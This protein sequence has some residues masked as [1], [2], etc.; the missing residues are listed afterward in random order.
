MKL[1][2]NP[3]KILLSTAEPEEQ[4]TTFGYGMVQLSSPDELMHIMNR[5]AVATGIYLNGHRSGSHLKAMGNVY[6][7]DIDTAPATGD[8]P[9]YQA[10][11]AKLRSLNISFV[12]VP[13]RNANEYPYKR[14][15]AIILDGNLPKQE[16]SFIEAANHILK[17]I[18]IDAV[19]INKETT[20][21]DSDNIDKA[22]AFDRV[23]FLAPAGINKDFTNYG[24]LSHA[25]DGEALKLPDHLKTV[26]AGTVNDDSITTS[27]MIQFVDG[28]TISIYNA[29]KI[30]PKGTKR[31]C[32]CPNPHHED[33]RPS[34]VFYHNDKNIV[35]HCSKCGNIKVSTNFI[36]TVP[37]IVH[38]QYNYSI[39]L[40]NVLQADLSRLTALIG[41]YS[42]KTDTS[43]IWAYRVA[44]VD[45][46]YQLL[47]AKVWLVENG[48]EVSPQPAAK[49]HSNLLDTATLQ[50]TTK[51]V[52]LPKAFVARD[53]DANAFTMLYIR[54]S[55]LIFKHYLFPEVTIHAY[56]QNIIAPDRSFANTCNRGL[57]YF[58]YVIETQRNQQGYPQSNKYF[59]MKLSRSDK[60]KSDK[61]RI[62]GMN[63]TRKAKTATAE[64]QVMKLI[65]NKKFVKANGKPNVSAIAKT[66]DKSRNTIYAA[67]KAI[68]E[69]RKTQ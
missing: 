22:V 45:D 61:Q 25:Y 16:D 38:D 47:L 69:R 27:Q 5:K 32:H 66:L 6:L 1:Y 60:A 11:E 26:Y 34:A 50:P 33:K 42:Y 67:I 62:D 2:H 57:A 35:I 53:H 48:F 43:V 59:A 51:N 54:A 68:N 10:I 4:N 14:H 29:K 18:G 46:I 37:E 31:V 36:P 3:N 30:T 49:T 8:A 13:S 28:T 23:R 56:N 63:R 58:E 24:D 7:V 9:Y 19:R 65:K 12:S 21:N 55:V 40:D 20:G 52:T 17:T 15:I 39:I 64:N 41:K 44:S